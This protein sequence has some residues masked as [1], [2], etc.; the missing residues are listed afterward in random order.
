MPSIFKNIINNFLE[1]HSDEA[2]PDRYKKLRRNITILMIIITTVPLLVMASVNYH[3]YNTRLTDEIVN[4]L[5]AISNKSK[6]SIELFLNER[7][8]TI[9][10]I[11]SLFSF[12]Q[13]SDKK[14][15]NSIFR[16]LSLE[17]KGFIDISLIDKTG[18]LRNYAGHY[19]LPTGDYSQEKWFHEVSIRG[20]YVSEV[21]T[22]YRG[23]PHISMAVQHMTK[24]E[25]IWILRATID[26]KQFESIIRAMGLEAESDAFLVRNNILQTH[27]KYYGK[28]LEKCPIPIPERGFGTTITEITDPDGRNIFMSSIYFEESDYV[29]VIIKPRSVLFKSWYTLK[30][31]LFAITIISIIMIIIIAFKLSEALVKNI[32][33]ADEKREMAFREVQHS[34][35]LSSIGRLAAGVAH[36][37]NNPMAI[38]NEKAGLM[39]DLIDFSPDFENKEK[40]LN[41][42]GSIIQSVERCKKITH[43]LLGFAKRLEV[44]FEN[45][46]LNN[47]I[48]EGLGFLESEAKHRNIEIRTN[49]SENLPRISAD[50]GQ[51]HQVFLNIITNGMVALDDGGTITIA[52]WDQDKDT[53]GVSITDNGCGM[54]KETMKHIFEPFF[55][56]KKDYGT[57]LGLPITYGIIQ[58]IGGTIKVESEENKGTTFYIYLKKNFDNPN[59]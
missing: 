54:S 43:R 4:P 53:V 49:F 45:L 39:N 47:V 37:I 13:L 9:R 56:T 48:T 44:V 22:G 12:E 26:I 23:Y 10:F 8:S 18:K 14:A 40:F 42:T 32:Q 34:Q 3:Q 36:E 21:F 50:K 38:I 46:D 59:I 27:S 25:E 31:D 15:L 20:T 28:V 5:R 24:N 57:G 2:S 30:T 6:H 7:L 58:K 16:V 19:V 29:L 52:T 33:E 1:F 17:F 35:K 55:T 11:E 51:L 41:L